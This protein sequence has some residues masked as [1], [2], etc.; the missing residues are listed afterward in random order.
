[1]FPYICC[2]LLSLNVFLLFFCSSLLL[3]SKWSSGMLPIS[4]Q[5]NKFILLSVLCCSGLGAYFEGFGGHFWGFG[6]HFWC[7]FGTRMAKWPWMAT[8]VQKGSLF[9][10][11]SSQFWLVLG[12]IFGKI[13]VFCV[14]W[15]V[16]LWVGIL[17]LLLEAHGCQNVCFLRWLTFTE[18]SNNDVS[19]G[20]ALLL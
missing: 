6:C 18:H 15:M 4:N 16:Q 11:K 7:I 5:T 2:Y 1:M 10:R 13:D 19:W 8:G 3:I 9:P 14:F 17:V 12:S 20:F